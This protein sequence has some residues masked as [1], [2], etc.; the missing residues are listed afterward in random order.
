MKRHEQ[1]GFNFF[2][3]CNENLSNTN[4]YNIARIIIEHIG[5]IKTVS[6]EQI[7]QEANISIASVS[8]FVQKIGY[9]S[10]QDFKDGLDYFIRNLNMVR[11]VSNMQQFMRTSLDNLADSL[12]VEAISNLRQTKL[13]LDMEKLVAITKLLLNSRSVTFIGDTHEMIDFYTCLLYTSRCV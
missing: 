5:D 2:R 13:N 11:T 9:S 1:L 3:Y 7:A 12:Y 6:L 8:R 4:E 10:F